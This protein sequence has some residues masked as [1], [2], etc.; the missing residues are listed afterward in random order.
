M[1]CAFGQLERHGPVIE[2]HVYHVGHAARDS[3]HTVPHVR[4]KDGH[5]RRKRAVEVI[6]EFAHLEVFDFGLEEAPG[7]GAGHIIKKLIQAGQG[8]FTSGE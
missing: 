4:G 2:H 1:F 3:A 8:R 6:E 5:I 7:P